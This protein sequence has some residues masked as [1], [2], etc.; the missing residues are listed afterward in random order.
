MSTE[1]CELTLSAFGSSGSFACNIDADLGCRDLDQQLP[2]FMSAA[3][4]PQQDASAPSC[5]MIEEALQVADEAP[6]SLCV[7]VDAVCPRVDCDALDQH[8]GDATLWGHRDNLALGCGA[9]RA[10]CDVATDLC[11]RFGQCD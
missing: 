1:T 11:Q 8:L 9:L 4:A 2:R 5:A 7:A 3:P 6:C 10:A